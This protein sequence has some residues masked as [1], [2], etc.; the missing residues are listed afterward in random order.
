[1]DL[2]VITGKTAGC[3]CQV[4]GRAAYASVHGP[5]SRG[6]GRFLG[7]IVTR[8]EH[9]D[10]RLIT[11]HSD[12]SWKAINDVLCVRRH[13]SEGIAAFIHE[14]SLRLEEAKEQKERQD[15]ARMNAS[16]VI[17]Y[18]HERRIGDR[19]DIDVMV[20]SAGFDTMQ[21][22]LRGHEGNMISLG[23]AQDGD[24]II[25]KRGVIS[26]E[27]PIYLDCD[28]TFSRERNYAGG[29][30]GGWSGGGGGGY[31]LGGGGGGGS[32]CREGEFDEK[33]HDHNIGPA[34]GGLQGC[35]NVVIKVGTEYAKGRE[36]LVGNP[37]DGKVSI[38]EPIMGDEWHFES[39]EGAEEFLPPRTSIYIITASGGAGEHCTLL[40]TLRSSAA[41]PSCMHAYMH[42]TYIHTYTHT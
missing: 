4:P 3:A 29:G 39:V 13:Q 37:G 35:S 17:L 21:G 18:K 7:K 24:E 16:F 23:P 10:E 31:G 2:A 30:G 12:T 1:M 9:G 40:P 26:V 27:A 19:P 42:H 11:N 20:Q 33:P 5:V 34:F 8:T 14:M 25:V 38:R 41:T 22:A 32:G 15:M 36:V 6:G 28:L